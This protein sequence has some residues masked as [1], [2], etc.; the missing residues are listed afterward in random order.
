[1]R[2][3][4]VIHAYKDNDN[5]GR[6]FDKN[7]QLTVNDLNEIGTLEWTRLLKCFFRNFPQNEWGTAI[8][9]R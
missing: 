2:Q 4:L 3:N 9:R 1:M 7:F 8:T 5:S 6:S